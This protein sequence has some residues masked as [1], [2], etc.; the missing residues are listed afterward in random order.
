MD[1]YL[2]KFA[3]LSH[4]DLLTRSFLIIFVNYTRLCMAWKRLH[5]LGMMNLMS[6]F[7]LLV[8]ITL[9]VIIVFFVY[10]NFG[11][12][13]NLVF[14][15]DDLIIIGNQSHY[16]EEF[17]KQLGTQFSIKDLGNLN[18]FLELNSFVLLLVNFL[19][20]RNIY[21]I[22]LT[23]PTWQMQISENTYCLWYMSRF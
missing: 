5:T 9:S 12:I 8:F 10:E 7:C 21:V 16:V 1:F 18:L 6:I 23:K 14:R 13:I 11:V 22:Y 15:V 19:T 2:K 20:N 17:I 4:L 3:C